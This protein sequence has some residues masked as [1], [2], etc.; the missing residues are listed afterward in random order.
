MII[1]S[2]AHCDVRFGWEHTPEVVLKM[3]AEANIDKAVITTYADIPGDDPRTLE[4]F[5]EAL[6]KY[7]DKIVAGFIRLNPWYGRK[8]E[9]LMEEVSKRPYMKGLKLHPVSC[10]MRPNDSPVLSLVKKAGE[11]GWPVYFHSGDEPMS[12]PT[13]IGKAAKACPGTKIIMGHTGGF[14][15]WKDAIKNA[16][17]YSNIYC[18]TSATPFANAIRKAVDTIGPERVIFGSDMPAMH[19][20]VELEKIEA[21]GLTEDEKQLVLCDNAKLMLGL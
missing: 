19:P 10:L 12:M 14:F 3:M 15:Y 9:E 8:A 20:T 4:R 7:P 21:A 5:I 2:H 1:D 6:E 13:Q 18:E 11:L 17:K 16:R